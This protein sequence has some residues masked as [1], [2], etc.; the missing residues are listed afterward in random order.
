MK[1]V[2]IAVGVLAAGI[3]AAIAALKTRADEYGY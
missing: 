1:K 3:A 2:I